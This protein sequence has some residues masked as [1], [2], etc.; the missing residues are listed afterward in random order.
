M[1]GMAQML[2]FSRSCVKSSPI[3]DHGDSDLRNPAYLQ[4]DSTLLEQI[5]GHL[6]KTSCMFALDHHS[7]ACK[8]LTFPHGRGVG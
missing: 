2:T 4:V 6:C 1:P 8:L 5:S 7:W 3:L